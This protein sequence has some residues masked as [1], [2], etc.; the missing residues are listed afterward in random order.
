MVATETFRDCA[1]DVD[2][3]TGIERHLLGACLWS[4]T[5]NGDGLDRA[6]EI[7]T[8]ADFAVHAHGLVFKTMLALRE[9]NSPV[10]AVTVHERMS[11]DGTAVELGHRPAGWFFDLISEVPGDTMA[12]YLAGRVKE[13]AR[14]R[15]LRHVAVEIAARVR[16]SGRPAADILAECEALLFAEGEQDIAASGPR[17]A[18]VLVRDGLARIDDRSSRSGPDG[19]ETG[20]CELDSYLAG[21]KAGQLIVVGA[22]PGCGKTAL[23]L[24]IASNVAASGFPVLFASLEMSA[25]EITDRLFAVRSGVPLRMIQSGQL[26]EHHSAAVCD[27][28]A[29]LRGEPLEVDD[30]PDLTAARLAAIVRRA[31]RRRGV[32]LVVVDYLQLMRPENERDPRHLQVGTIARRVK[33]LARA[34]NVP[35][36]LLAQLNREAENRTGGKPKLSDL[37]ESGEIE[38]HADAVLLLNPQPDQ[39]PES[40]VWAT[41]CIIAKNRSGPTGELTLAYRR[42]ITRF[43]NSPR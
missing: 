21:L 2:R 3:A 34:C 43:E 22:R 16:D 32:K 29:K 20:F 12:D 37:R 27:A 41:D 33:Q 6:A 13:A 8:V 38:A 15:K 5:R 9:E 10:T 19:L 31:V 7:V 25:T 26:N 39:P 30:A 4:D 28:A 11:G 42:T 40:P 18:D 1:N 23:A 14:V 36:L 35:V 24:G 17:S